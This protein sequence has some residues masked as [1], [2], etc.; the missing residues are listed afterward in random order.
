MVTP[1][2]PL[3]MSNLKNV[4]NPVSLRLFILKDNATEISFNIPFDQWS[5]AEE[6]REQYHMRQGSTLETGD[7]SIPQ[8]QREIEL[9]IDFLE[10]S[11]A[12]AYGQGQGQGQEVH[13][14]YSEYESVV[15]ATDDSQG[16][17]KF[18]TCVFSEFC[19]R[20]CKTNNIHVTTASFPKKLRLHAIQTYYKILDLLV[21][22]NTNTNTIES[23]LIEKENSRSKKSALFQAVAKHKASIFAVFGGQG[24]ED[25]FEEIK[26]IYNTYETIVKSY[27]ERMACILEELASKPELLQFF[28]KGLHVLKW[29]EEPE[30]LPD[31]KY[32]VNAPISLPLVGLCQLLHYCVLYK[33][34]GKT[35]DEMRR[36]F[37]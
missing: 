30:T 35:P 19:N 28:P 9:F 7:T 4:T 13:T 3:G 16:L 17:F 6:V 15:A 27:L 29:L 36:C 23:A 18:I 20:Y 25:Y 10:F 1:L 22:A 24:S 37:V 11:S 32:L 5:V 21:S 8:E 26:E 34:L 12:Y 14:Q 2:T 33:S 31:T